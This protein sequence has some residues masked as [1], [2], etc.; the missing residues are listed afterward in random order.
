MFGIVDF[1]P[2]YILFFFGALFFSISINRLLLR[3]SR[4]LGIRNQEEVIRWSAQSKPALGGISFYIVFLLSIAFVSVLPNEAVGSMN[5]E[6]FGL[7]AASTMG[8][9]I[10]LADDAYNTIP[11]LKFLGQ[12][13]CASIL[14]STNNYIPITPDFALNYIFS[15]L[16]VIGIMNSINMLDNMD[17]ITASISLAI[18]IAVIMV[19]MGN[20][21]F[22]DPYLIVLIGVGAG[23]IGFLFYNW[24][25]SKMYMG[26]TGSQFLGVFLAGIACTYLWQFRDSNAEYFQIKQF[27]V[28]LLAFILPLIDTTTVFIRRLWRGQSPFVGGKDHTT[29]HLVYFGFSDKQVA[30]IFC[31]ISLVSLIMI[32]FIIQNFDHWTFWNSLAVV[33]YALVLFALFQVV[34][35]KGKKK[36]LLLEDQKGD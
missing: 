19:I 35:N 5:R 33:L 29:H 24:H 14:I 4:N 27:L 2:V 10:G 15:L 23:L 11:V 22:H 28:P 9:L 8:F 3:F 1:L 7:F 34:Y 36:K 26:D 25:P 12:V 13:T 32:Y 16:W 31:A 30:Y 17:G 20:S 21:S 6:L 18:I